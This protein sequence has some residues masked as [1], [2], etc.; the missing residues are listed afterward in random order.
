MVV[1][2]DS[3][4]AAAAG[5]QRFPKSLRVRRR[6][7]YLRLQ[8]RG[9]RCGAGRFVV[10]CVPRRD[11]PSRIGITASRKTGNAVVRNRVKRLVREFFRR[12]HQHISPPQDILVIARPSAADAT[13]ADVCGE[14]SRALRLPRAVSGEQ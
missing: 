8:S 1:H 12:H 14:L 10:L 9:R 7:E 4:G 13:W 11:Q 5:S 6:N 3:G 2:R